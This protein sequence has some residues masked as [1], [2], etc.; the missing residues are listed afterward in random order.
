MRYK[1]AGLTL[2]AWMAVCVTSLAQAQSSEKTSEGTRTNVKL[3]DRLDRLRQ[4]I[5]GNSQN[6]N[7]ESSAGSAS[8]RPSNFPSRAGSNAHRASRGRTRRPA[9]ET[10]A[11]KFQPNSPPAELKPESSAA[12]SQPASSASRAS[13][14]RIRTA[15]RRSAQPK[16]SNSGGAAPLDVSV[17]NEVSESTSASAPTERRANTARR[18]VPQSEAASPFPRSQAVR[19]AANPSRTVKAEPATPVT[20]QPRERIVPARS[21][22]STGSSVI[23]RTPPVA[24]PSPRRESVISKSATR[25]E[26]ESEPTAQESTEDVDDLGE[27]AI[28]FAQRS[29]LLRVETLGPRRIVVGKESSYT[30]R[31][32]NLGEVSAN[33]VVVKVQLPKDADVVS[34]TPSHGS[35]RAVNGARGAADFLEWEIDS[36]PGRSNEQLVLKMIPRDSREFELAVNWSSTASRS[37]TRIEVQE[38]KLTLDLEGPNEVIFGDA[39]VYRLTV[40]NPGTGDAENVNIQLMPINGGNQPAADHTLGTIAAGESKMLEVELTAR[41]AGEVRIHAIVQG[42]GSLRAEVD[43]RVLVRRADLKVAVSGPPMKYAGTLG[44]YAIQV[45]N[46]GTATAKQVK[47]VASLP[48]GVSDVMPSDQG[49]V[50]A[51]R[52]KVEWTIDTL[53]AGQSRELKLR[54][55][56]KSAGTN[57]LQIAAET[58]D[59]LV[60]KGRVSTHV[61]ATADLKLEVSDPAGPVAVGEELIYEVRIRNRGSKEAQGV[62]VFGFFSEGLEPVE[63]LQGTGEMSPGQVLFDTIESLP[64]GGEEVLKIVAKAQ[65]GGTHIFHAEVRCKPLDT[66]LVAEESTLFYEMQARAP[67]TPATKAATPPTP[68]KAKS[69]APA[70]PLEAKPMPTPTPAPAPYSPPE[71]SVPAATKQAPAA[72]SAP[73]SVRRGSVKAVQSYSPPVSSAAS[74]APLAPEAEG[75]APAK[76]IA[77][78]EAEP[79]VPAK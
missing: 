49:R 25:A 12:R 51:G 5:F 73:A 31:I 40:A 27:E 18:L 16:S 76:A 44:S 74:P 29:P 4:D 6:G 13:Q 60:A 77:P 22:A 9:Q 58:V 33:G 62:D 7:R 24:S 30:V 20:A 38:P 14:G 8:S 10:Q 36:L 32:Q 15:D 61:E 23:K 68:A 53:R 65:K 1:V 64:A 78:T 28:L 79:S 54:Y 55:V 26:A 63:V 41:Q 42:D 21:A 17:G 72:A 35:A 11:P 71:A 48:S 67:S 45:S 66:R 47:I 2:V 56:V 43:E 52:G 50:D 69:G 37:Q 46:P 75:S 59:E 19:T 39:K 70:D 34:T 57:V 3:R